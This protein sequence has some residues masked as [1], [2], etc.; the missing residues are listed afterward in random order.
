MWERPTRSFR[1]IAQQL[2][3]HRSMVW[4]V[5]NYENLQ[6]Q[7]L[8]SEEFAHRAN[9][10]PKMLPQVDKNN[11]FPSWM[12]W[13]DKAIFSR[14]GCFNQYMFL[15]YGIESLHL[16]HKRANQFLFSENMSASY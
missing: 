8:V 13:T 16:T 10:V 11:Q 4:K 1:R 9:I 12:I 6:F 5:I 7:I 15:F 3:L 14:D 2:G